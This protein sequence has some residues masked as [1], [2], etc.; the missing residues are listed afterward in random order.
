MTRFLPAIVLLAGGLACAPGGDDTGL[1]DGRDTS[2]DN[3][4]DGTCDRASCNSRCVA[5]GYASGVCRTNGSCAC[6]GSG[7]VAAECTAQCLAAGYDTGE[8]RATGAC[9]CSSADGGTPSSTGERCA[10]GI[11]N[12][13]NGVVDEGCGCTLGETQPCYSGPAESRNVGGCREGTQDCVGEGQYAHWGPCTGEQLPQG[14]TCDGLD[15]DCDVATDED[16][17]SC[18]PSSSV[19]TQCADFQDNDCDTVADCFD[20]DCPP[21]CGEELCDDGLDNNCDGQT[22]EYCDEPCAPNESAIAGTCGDGLDN[23]CD[24]RQDCLDLDCLPFCCGAEVCDD[25]ADNDC[26]GRI[27]CR[28][29]ECCLQAACRG[30]ESCSGQC[31][32]PGTYRYCDTPTYCSWGRQQC[33]P[34]GRWGSCEETTRPAGCDGYFYTAACCLSLG[35]CCQ[36]YGR[37]ESSLPSDASIGNCDGISAPCS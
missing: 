3:G 37:Y 19:E 25:G 20:P 12:N 33:R 1:A 6:A 29:S 7:C 10:D 27:D 15:N 31:C 22:D 34:D 13:H 9:G 32:L 24:G 26:D 14:E 5:A 16:C 17:G 4:G 18:V 2:R 28:D 23:D 35:A 36:N 30:T 8:C 11:D 21:C